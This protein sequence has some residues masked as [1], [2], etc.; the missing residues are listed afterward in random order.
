MASISLL[1]KLTAENFDRICDKVMALDMSA[2]TLVMR[3]LIDQIFDKALS[4]HSFTDTYAKLCSNM[5]QASEFLQKQFV[6]VVEIE[7]SRPD[8]SAFCWRDGQSKLKGM[9]QEGEGQEVRPFDEE[10]KCRDFAFKQTHF[11]RILL[12]KCQEE[13]EKEDI[14]EEH[15]KQQQEEERTRLA[16]GGKELT[17]DEKALQAF[18]RKRERKELRVRRLGNTLFIG[19]LFKLDMLSERIMH[20]CIADLIGNPND[21]DIESVEALCKLLTS[22]GYT[23]DNRANITQGT[24]KQLKKA[25]RNKENM[26]SYFKTLQDFA[27]SPKLD[28]R[29]QFMCRDVIDMRKAGWKERRKTLKVKTIA[30]VHAEA[31]EE[32]RRQ[33]RSLIELAGVTTGEAWI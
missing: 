6:S 19:S 8:M 29:T 32:Q 17:D 23:L 4:Q 10:Q 28:K 13:F 21:P 27:V 20:N 2:G 25:S 22:I 7:S 30:E 31:A 12:N 5:S 24:P 9:P 26:R 15:V 11:W 16:S 33:R 18:L 1:N 3:E 14:Y